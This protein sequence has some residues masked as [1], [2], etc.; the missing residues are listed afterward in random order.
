[1]D[2]SITQVELFISKYTELNL[3]KY[4][5]PSEQFEHGLC[6][7][8]I[9][10][11]FRAEFCWEP[12]ASKD[13]DVL[14]QLITTALKK[15]NFKKGRFNA[16]NFWKIERKVLEIQEVS[17][18]PM[19]TLSMESLGDSESLDNSD[20]LNDLELTNDTVVGE[21]NTVTAVLCFKSTVLSTVQSTLLPHL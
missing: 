14:R 17:V 1:M 19:D 10:D 15:A 12:K 16:T 8:S 3:A 20:S 5:L 21:V 6:L 7:S 11:D 9:V 2:S 18:E 4:I 13:L